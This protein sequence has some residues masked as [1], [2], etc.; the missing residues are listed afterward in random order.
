MSRTLDA[1]RPRIRSRSYSRMRTIGGP[2]CDHSAPTLEMRAISLIEELLNYGTWYPSAI[3]LNT[4]GS[5]RDGDELLTDARRI[6]A[7]AKRK[8]RSK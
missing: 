6:L 7:D 2:G 5:N 3:E 4:Y 8:A 1:A